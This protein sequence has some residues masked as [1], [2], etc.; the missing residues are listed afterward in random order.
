MQS[1][2]KLKYILP[3][4]FISCTSGWL[5][6]KPDIALTVP[7]DIGDYQQ[8]LDNRNI[9]GVNLPGLGEIAADDYY[10]T[11]AS[12]DALATPLER[13]SYI[14][15]ADIFEGTE[16]S[17][18]NLAYNQIYS[19]NI[20]LD[21]I[22]KLR[23]NPDIAV[24]AVNDI[25]GQAL[26]YRS[27]CYWMLAETF[28]NPYNTENR[29]DLG[30]PLNLDAIV[31]KKLSRSTLGQLY[32]Q[33]IDDLIIAEGLLSE[34]Q[35][36]KTRPSAVAARAML[37]RILLSIDQYEKALFWTQK[38]TVSADGILDYRELDATAQYP[39]PLFNKEVIWHA[40][41]SQYANSTNRI[42][43]VDT[44]LYKSY[45]EDDL[46]KS[47]FFNATAQGMQFKGNYRGTRFYPFCGLTYAEILLITA[48]CQIRLGEVDK[49]VESLFRLLQHR[50]AEN[51]YLEFEP[52]EE[53]RIVLAERRKELAFRGLRWSDLRR[54]NRDPRFETTIKRVVNNTLYELTPNSVR[55]VYPLPPSE[56]ILN[57]LQQNPR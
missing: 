41:I 20:V 15:G 37:A 10:L 35:L 25:Q 23:G 17:N 51:S 45:R 33:V 53:L 54:L 28:C 48:E 16:S 43:L 46:R 4:T 26:F 36:V 49:G 50:Y 6:Q 22:G 29:D 30:L 52:G 39:I 44:V 9:F 40:E 38:I 1:L 56:I 18:W 42:G 13:N 47:I 7:S 3:L 34:V 24:A 21:G 55:Y 11:D 57:K 31:G 19:A 32:D 8:L 5:D 12:W 27:V 2:R 14:W